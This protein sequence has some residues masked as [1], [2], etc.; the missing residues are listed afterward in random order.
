M[1][2]HHLRNATMVMETGANM[3]LVDPMLSEKGGTGPSFTLFRHKRQ[4]N[5]IIDLPAGAMNLVEKTTHCLITH[6]HPDHIDE[7]GEEL[8]ERKNIP[9]TCSIKDEEALKE[10]GLNVVQT[11]DYHTPQAFLGGKI[12]GIP[13]THGYGF[14]AKLMGN[15]MGFYLQ[16]PA[17]KSVYLSSDTIYTDQVNKVL[18]E[19]K[20]DIS[21]AACGSAQM[22]VLKPLLMTMEDIIRFVR[23][24][25]GTVIANH[26]QAVNHCPT[27]RK[28]LKETLTKEG[29]INKAWIPED[30]EA[31]AF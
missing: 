17:E 24:A 18:R 22:D 21:V 10:K 13:A 16:L 29:L 1:K 3:I 30:G 14:V 7:A 9:I 20:P 5:P 6:L 11:L 15:V 27:T 19:Y 31:M 28:Q 8:L 12:E 2:I 4:R 25:P 23:D 26:L